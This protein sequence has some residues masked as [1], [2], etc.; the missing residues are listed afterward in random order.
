MTTTRTPREAVEA[1]AIVCRESLAEGR[2]SPRY[3]GPSLSGA[4]LSDAD[5]TGA[6]L[7]GADLSGA[8]LSGANLFGA[9]LV[10]ADLTRARLTDADLTDADLRSADLCGARVAEGEVIASVAGRDDGY[11]WHALALAGG[12]CVLQYG[13]DRATLAEWRTRGPE[14][15]ARH[16]H[17]PDHWA[18]GPAVA[19]A[20]AEALI[21][22]TPS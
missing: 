11:Y 7:T 16:N 21:S 9:T 20:A 22:A 15:G 8:D 19:I 14:Y 3:D 1:H 13:C 10:G 6:R 4:D 18:T 2:P 12:G 17:Q 5:L